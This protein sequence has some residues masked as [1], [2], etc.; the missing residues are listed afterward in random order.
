[1]GTGTWPRS[2]NC[3]L[4]NEKDPTTTLTLGYQKKTY[5]KAKSVFESTLLCFSLVCTWPKHKGL[6]SRKYVQWEQRANN[7]GS[8][9]ATHERLAM[10]VRQWSHVRELPITR[11]R[12]SRALQRLSIGVSME[13]RVEQ[14]LLAALVE[15][16]VSHGFLTALLQG[17]G[18]LPL[19]GQAA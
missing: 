5:L 4:P 14:Q 9:A 12:L 11:D 8:T 2:N 17:V 16:S 18:L 19:L 1:M 6:R 3:M 10:V 13:P 7:I 15:S